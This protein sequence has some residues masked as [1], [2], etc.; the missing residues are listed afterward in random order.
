MDTAAVVQAYGAAWNEPDEDARRRLLESAWA[1][2]ASYCDPTATANDREALV[3]HIGGFQ[4]ALPGHR[5]DMTTVVDEHDQCLRFGWAM[6]GRD[7]AVLIEGTDFG[8]LAA[9]GRL[10]RIVGFFG[11]LAPLEAGQ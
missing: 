10:Q 11:P 7:G 4:A 9:D 8:T 1:D 6:R 3:A 2:D 5:I